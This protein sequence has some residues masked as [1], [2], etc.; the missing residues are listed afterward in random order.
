LGLA[1]GTVR[2]PWKKW[3]LALD[4]TVNLGI[5]CIFKYL[6][7]F[8]DS[9][10]HVLSPAGV[11]F[12]P[13]NILLPVGISFFVFEAMSYCIDVYRGHL[14]PYDNW[15]HFALFIFFFPRMI[16]GP[17][18]RPAQFLP[19]LARPIL[20]TWPNVVIGGQMFLLG[21][22]K[23]I[24]IADHLAGF[25]D[26]VFADPA[27]CSGIVVWQA[28]IAYAI[29]IFCDFSGYT[30][31]ALGTAKI[32]GFDGTSRSLPGCA[33]ICTSPWAATG[34]AVCAPI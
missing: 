23:K 24:V 3:L 4:V 16:A 10:N 34:T 22:A 30:D 14:K 15:L 31:M 1:L 19:Q 26:F 2:Q 18:I 12:D 8:I 7:F 5:L 9:F 17:I 6:N 27:N 33:T 32:L 21:L 28:V 29:Q 11:H 25:V 20:I 13:L